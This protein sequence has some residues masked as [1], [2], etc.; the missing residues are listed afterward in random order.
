MSCI[1]FFEFLNLFSS[2]FCHHVFIISRFPLFGP[3]LQNFT[4]SCYYATVAK[5]ATVAKTGAVV[6]L[7]IIAIPSGPVTDDTD[8][9][10]DQSFRCQTPFEI[11]TLTRPTLHD[12]IDK[13]L[14][15]L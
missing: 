2:V 13:T 14:E 10:F 11:Y 3:A 7:V 4:N 8:K 1:E 12:I 5:L 9:I 6:R 15:I